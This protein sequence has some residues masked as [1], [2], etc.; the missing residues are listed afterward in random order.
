MKKLVLTALSTCLLLSAF[1]GLAHAGDAKLKWGNLDNF[2]DV[3]PG[4]ELKESFRE[5]MVK[6]FGRV[7]SKFAKKLPDGYQLDV[8]VNDVDLAGDVRP[9]MSSVAQIRLMTTIYW[10]R[11]KFHYELRNDKNEMISSGDEQLSDMG[12]LTNTRMTLAGATSFEF[13]EKMISDW[14]RR[15]ANAGIFPSKDAKAVAA[16]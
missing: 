4:N 1:S 7:F 3:N 6:D 16:K 8:T 12:Y 15:Q 13:E 9:N 2:T 5:R 14:F 10:P 11:M